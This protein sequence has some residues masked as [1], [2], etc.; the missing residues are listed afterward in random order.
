MKTGTI[1]FRILQQQSCLCLEWGL[2][3]LLGGFIKTFCQVL[4]LEQKYANLQ[5]NSTNLNRQ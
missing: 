1:Y 2:I 3:H 5:C 4:Q